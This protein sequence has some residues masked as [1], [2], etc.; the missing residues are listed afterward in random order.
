MYT[1]TN[2]LDSVSVPSGCLGSSSL[3]IPKQP[4]NVVVVINCVSDHS[5]HEIY[6][7]CLMNAKYVSSSLSFTKIPH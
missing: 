4:C 7:K 6:F 5:Q 2:V 1:E 3:H